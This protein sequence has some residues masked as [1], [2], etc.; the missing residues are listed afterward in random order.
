VIA[1]LA[2]A[3]AAP[4]RAAPVHFERVDILSEDPGTWLV[5]DAPRVALSPRLTALRWLEQ[6]KVS[7]A[8][9]RASLVIGVSASSQS[10]SLRRPLSHRV[11]LYGSVGLTTALGL[12][13]GGLLGAEYWRGPVRIGVGL[14]AHAGA[15]WAR[16][17]WDSWRILPGVGIGLGRSPSP[18]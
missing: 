4:D 3:W 6:V 18:F 13:R 1:L 17:V 2:I 12:P 10:L 16:P 9:P 14:H 11:P 7:A 5:D 15:T 8:I